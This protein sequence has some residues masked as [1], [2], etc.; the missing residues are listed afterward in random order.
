MIAIIAAIDEN[1]ALGKNGQLLC[2]LPL[3]LKHFKKTT[4][5]QSV[6]MGRKTFESIG[7][8]LPHRENFV[9][10]RQKELQLLGCICVASLDDAL[11][12]KQHGDLWILG[13]GEVYAQCLPF[14]D[15]MVLTRIHHR[16]EEA[17]TFFPTIDFSQW[18]IVSEEFHAAS[19]ENNYP[20]T[21]VTMHRID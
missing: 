8:A 12:K 14:V 21:F 18:R 11:A 15:K 3:D 17:D 16:F 6:L 4:L 5:H 13:G 19:A 9:L 1:N 2:H 20:L 10:T 7:R